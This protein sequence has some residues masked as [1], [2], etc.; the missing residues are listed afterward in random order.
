M[1]C[2]F[3]CWKRLRRRDLVDHHPA[4]GLDRHE[5]SIAAT[6]NGL[7]E[8]RRGRRIVQRLTQSA[9]RRVQPVVEVDERPVGPEPAPEVFATDHLAGPFE[10]SVQEGQRLV[11]QAERAAFAPQVS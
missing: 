6:W 10:Q 5:Q 11:R 1:S 8:S 9:D 3:G 4:V 2:G 7:D